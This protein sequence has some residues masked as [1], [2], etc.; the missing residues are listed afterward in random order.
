MLPSFKTKERLWNQQQRHQ[1]FRGWESSM[2]D[3]RSWSNTTPCE[4]EGEQGMVA[5]F[6]PLGKERLQL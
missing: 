4:A 2:S 1:W 5:V 3:A 6:T